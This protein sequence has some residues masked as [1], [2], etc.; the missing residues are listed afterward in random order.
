MLNMDSEDVSGQTH[1][2][3]RDD[4]SMILSEYGPGVT[5][6]RPPGGQW[7]PV[8]DPALT[9]RLETFYRTVTGRQSPPTPPLSSH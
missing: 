6:Q 8:D 9:E 4:G 1:V 2:I 3:I 7:V 5:I